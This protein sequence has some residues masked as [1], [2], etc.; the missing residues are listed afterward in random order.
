MEDLH[1]VV[2][3]HTQLGVLEGD[4]VLFL[5]RLS[6]RDAVISLTRIAGRPPLH[7]SSSGQVLLAFAPADQ[8]ERALGGTLR[9]YTSRTPTDPKELRARLAAI[10][11]AGYALCAGHIDERATGIAVPCTLRAETWWRRRAW[12]CPTM[13]TPGCRSRRCARRRW[14]FSARSIDENRVGRAAVARR[15]SVHPLFRGASTT[16]DLRVVEKT[17]VA[18]GV[19]TLTLASSGG[20]RLPDWAPGAHVDPV[21]PAGSCISTRCAATAGTLSVTGW[22]CCV[23]RPDHAAAADTAPGDPA[24]CPLAV[25]PRRP[26]PAIDGL[27]GRPRTHGDRVCVRPRDEYGLLDLDSWLT[28]LAPGTKVCCC[29][30]EPLPS[31]VEERRAGRRPGLLRT[32]RFVPRQQNA[33]S[34][35]RD[36]GPVVHLDRAALTGWQDF[37][38]AAGVGQGSCWRPIRPG[39]TRRAVLSRILGPRALRKLRV[40]TGSARRS[41]P[42][43]TATFFRTDPSAHVGFGMGIHQRVGRHVARLEA[44]ALLTAS[45]ARVRTIELAGTTR[46]HHDNTLCAWESIPV[47]VTRWLCSPGSGNVITCRHRSRGDPRSTRNSNGSAD[48]ADRQGHERAERRWGSRSQHRGAG[49]DRDPGQQAGSG[50]VGTGPH[51]AGNTHRVRA[52]TRCRQPARRPVHRVVGATA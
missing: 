37:Q 38:S 16:V 22:A 10:R 20:G 43:T 42:P 6:G 13:P 36:A 31:A 50:S 41:G 25:A 47:A 8:Q 9:A 27:P 23:N 46:R 33:P 39:M 4:E 7:A 28:A 45:A 44:E 34:K 2:G 19:V 49:Y 12:W 24:R 15:S 30:P 52:G 21:L 14:A 5:E 17:V 51:H 11:R 32:E 29:G 18:E 48:D 40:A 3:L 35:L 26:G 1:A